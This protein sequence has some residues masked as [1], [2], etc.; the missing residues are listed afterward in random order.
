MLVVE[1]SR[2][3]LS[4][5]MERSR[6]FRTRMFGVVERQSRHSLISYLEGGQEFPNRD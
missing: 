5:R 4:V 2:D 1:R 6:D 3:G